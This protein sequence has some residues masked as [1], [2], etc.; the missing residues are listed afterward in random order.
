MSDKREI[1]KKIGLFGCIATGI[2]AIIGS[3][4][5][6]ALPEAINSIGVAVIPAYL[7]ATIY[8]ICNM[9]PNVYASSV[10]PTT[11]SF[12]LF[13]TK[14]IHPFCGLWMTLQ[15]ML[16]PALIATFAVLFADYFVLLFPVL[17][18]YKIAVG[19]V[20][21][22]VFGIIAYMGNHTFASVSSVMV[23]VMLTAIIVYIILG[24]PYI[25]TSRLTIGETFRSG[26]NLTAFSAAVGMLSSTLSGAG[27]ISQIADDMK[28]PRRDIPLTLIL[29]PAIVCVIYVLMA[30]VTIGVM[31]D[32]ALTS[33]ADVGSI[34]M[35]SVLLNF[36]IVGG[37][38]C[39]ILTSMVP[40][41]MLSC[42]L[43]QVSAENR[44]FPEAVA[45]RTAMA[46]RLLFWFL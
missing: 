1:T 23:V 34:Y 9:F 18:A 17:A 32:G 20:V 25:D 16:Q 19:V 28:N 8:I 24:A 13:S 43:I 12:F 33:L 22:I 31:P 6:G 3:G 4:V 27:S 5:F 30:V 10:I 14:L 36:F 26:V 46:F 42:A 15:G 39:G 7:A 45:K 44:V 29:A 38:I 2:G 35:G 40:V 41:V 11:G 37:P 21:L